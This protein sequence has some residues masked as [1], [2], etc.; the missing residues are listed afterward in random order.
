MTCTCSNQQLN[1]VGCECDAEVNVATDELQRRWVA[2]QASAA[3]AEAEYYRREQAAHDAEVAH[4][5]A[6]EAKLSAE[7]AAFD[8]DGYN[9]RCIEQFGL[10]PA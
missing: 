10:F 9:N 3:E 2:E 6:E 5:V 7:P 8:W 1:L 4:W